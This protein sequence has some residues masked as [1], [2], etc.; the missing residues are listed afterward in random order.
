MARDRES[1]C[2]ENRRPNVITRMD[3]FLEQTIRSSIAFLGSGATELDRESAESLLFVAF[4]AL[5]ERDFEKGT[6]RAP[7]LLEASWP[8][9]PAACA[10]VLTA[11]LATDERIPAWTDA[12]L[13][14]VPV[15]R[16]RLTPKLRAVWDLHR[17]ATA[18]GWTTLARL[19]LVEPFPMPISQAQLGDR[20]TARRTLRSALARAEP[21]ITQPILEAWL[22]ELDRPGHEVTKTMARVIRDVR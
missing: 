10:S 3:R 14:D 6:H 13:A 5:V 22:D 9:E 20:D 15:I 7:A 1:R 18:E 4:S 16:E 19:H 8:S 11:W 21:R 2:P 17:Q 12:R